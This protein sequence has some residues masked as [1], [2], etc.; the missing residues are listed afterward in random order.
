LGVASAGARPPVLLL[1]SG[2]DGSLLG[3]DSLGALAGPVAAA[4][5]G[6]V[7]PD[8][9][10]TPD[11][12]KVAAADPATL[13]ALT[14]HY[15]TGL[16]LLGQ[17]DGATS[18]W[19]L[20]AGGKPQTWSDQGLSEDAMLGAAAGTLL[21]HVGSQ[22]NVIGS[23]SSQGEVWVSGLNSAMDYA[24]LLNTLRSDPMVQQVDTTGAADGG[25]YLSVKAGL[26]LNALVAH[27]AAGGR[28]LQT[29]PHTGADV[30][31]HWLH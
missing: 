26:P 4:G 5:Y 29:D 9:G 11:L 16:I 22:L 24:N 15:N 1:V 30:S 3:K 18:Q 7:Y 8:A 31:L 21:A 14:A 23:G 19:T 6:V 2:K 12:A 27:L 10:A 28:M 25:I 20:L 13:A 17:L